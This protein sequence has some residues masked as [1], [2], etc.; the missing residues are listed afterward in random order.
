MALEATT[1]QVRPALQQ[2]APGWAGTASRLSA[3]VSLTKPRIIE[4]LLITT[5]PTMVVAAHGWPPLRAVLVTLAGGTLS[6]GGANAANMYLE[7]D[8]DAVMRRTAHRPLVTGAVSPRAALVFSVCLEVTAF[9]ALWLGVNILCAAL[10]LSAALFYVFV[11]TALLKRSSPQNIVIGGAAGAVPVLV[12]WAAVR[13]SLGWAPLML[14]ALVLFWT[15]PHFWSLAIRYR[16]DY[17]KAKVPM[18]PVVRSIERTSWEIFAYA[19]ATLAA[20]FGFGAVAGMHWLYWL[21]AGGAGLV[22]VALS[23][24]LVASPRPATAMRV[25]HWSITYLSVVFVAVAVDIAIR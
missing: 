5:L 22:F 17:A 2:R 20:S 3:F 14:F 11:Y 18:M 7:R 23:V 24:Q 8:I 16:D 10:A 12:G 4:L 6:A 19:L 21:V 25:F 9:V 15:P 13:G 1:A